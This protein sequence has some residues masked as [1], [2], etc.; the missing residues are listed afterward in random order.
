M[1]DKSLPLTKKNAEQASKE[2]G[3]LLDDK[4]GSN[5]LGKKAPAANLIA[6]EPPTG[7]SECQ[8]PGC[9]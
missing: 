3:E 2:I 4:E 7:S 8:G 9:S 1:T 5:E 6:S